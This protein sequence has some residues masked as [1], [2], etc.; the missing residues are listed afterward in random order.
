[1]A[2]GSSTGTTSANRRKGRKRMPDCHQCLNEWPNLEDAPLKSEPQ[3]QVCRNCART[4][5]QVFAFY[6]REGI[7]IQKLVYDAGHEGRTPPTPPAQKAGK[8]P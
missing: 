2:A 3:R 6:R 7:D 5:K 1:M 4:Q 8:A